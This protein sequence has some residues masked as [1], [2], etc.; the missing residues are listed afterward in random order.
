[1]LRGHTPFLSPHLKLY[2]ELCSPPSSSCTS[3]VPSVPN[4]FG[5]KTAERRDDF[6]IMIAQPSIPLMKAK[7]K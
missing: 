7:S 2:D 1:M 6:G 5:G 3:P 4:A